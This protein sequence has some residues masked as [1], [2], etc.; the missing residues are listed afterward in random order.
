[1]LYIP[2]VLNPNASLT[3]GRW[4]NILLGGKATL[5]MLCLASIL[6]SRPKVVC[7]Y[8]IYAVEAGLLSVLGLSFVHAI[9]PYDLL[10][11][12][13]ETHFKSF[14]VFLI[15]FSKCP[16]LGTIKGN[17]PPTVDNISN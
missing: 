10:H 14:Q 13:T 16:S 4:L 6:L 15:Y 3:K 2:G 5:L 8:G 1:M 11:L 7:V 12:S 17:T 9:V